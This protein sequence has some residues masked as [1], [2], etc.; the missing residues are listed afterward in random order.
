MNASRPPLAPPYKGGE[1]HV[2][3]RPP[4]TDMLNLLSMDTQTRTIQGFIASLKHQAAAFRA[5]FLR[6]FRASKSTALL[7]VVVE[8]VLGTAVTLELFIISNLVDSLIGARAIETVTTDVTKYVW[9]QIGLFLGLLPIFLLHNQF[10]GVVAR[11]GKI[12]REGAFLVGAGVT[13]LPVSLLFVPLFILGGFVERY[14]SMRS[15]T[16]IY[17]ILTIA[18]ASWLAR[19]VVLAGI[20]GI[21]TVGEVLLWAGATLALAGFLALRPYLVGGRNT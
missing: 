17:S 11:L 16:I 18:I 9:Y 4:H 14:V 7:L 1:P 10:D 3:P 19:N 2:A 20:Y 12:I 5:D 21:A 15:V 8:V 13:A 6:L